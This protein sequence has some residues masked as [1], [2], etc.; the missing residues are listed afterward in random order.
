MKGLFSYESA[1]R[2]YTRACV[3]DFAEDN[4]QYAEIRPNFMANNAVKKDDASGGYSNFET[5]EIIR[6]EYLGAVH[7]I[8]KQGGYFG[9]LKV[10][11]CHPRSF[12]PPQV[13]KALDECLAMKLRRPG[14]I[15]GMLISSSC[16]V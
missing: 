7:E 10:I 15:C 5:L 6:E 1:F 2:A 9:G 14:L 3:K 11:Y 8:Q 13:A 4:I 16:R 12:S